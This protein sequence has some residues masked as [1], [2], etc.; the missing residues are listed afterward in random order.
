MNA[1]VVHEN[2]PRR[3]G[4]AGD[5]KGFVVSDLISR[6][7][8]ACSAGL[9][10]GVPEFL[11]DRRAKPVGGMTF[12]PLGKKLDLYEQFRSF[13]SDRAD[14]IILPCF[15]AH[16]FLEEVQGEVRLPVFPLFEALLAK[17]DRDYASVRRIGVLSTDFVQDSGL[18]ERHLAMSNRTVV[19]P[20]ADIRK[21]CVMPAMAAGATGF[22]EGLR[23]ACRHLIAAGAE[24][25]VPGNAELFQATTS[26]QVEGL[27]VLDVVQFY[28]D[29]IVSTSPAPLKKHFKIGVV[30]GVGPAATV[31]LL[32][33]IVVN[34]DARCDQEHV[35]IVVE[36]NPQIPDR[37]ANLLNGGLDPSVALYATCRRLQ[38]DD[39]NIIVIP[40][41]T[42]HAFVPRIQPYL[43]IP[44]VNMLHATMAYLGDRFP[45]QK[46]VGLLATSGTIE[47]RVYHDAAQSV[48]V[49]LLVPD[50]ENQAQVM[51]AIYGPRGVKAGYTEGECVERLLAAMTSLVLRGAEILILGCTELPLLMQANP[52][53]P[54]AGTTVAIVDP[55]EI[56][57][58]TCIR[59]AREHAAA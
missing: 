4:V 45:R 39:A 47:T 29:S 15:A 50:E 40:C 33:K 6:I 5:S 54:M 44:I 46:R 17:L 56:L 12:D 19:Y 51:A 26:L 1:S 24:V 25:I 49:E 14:A 8:A 36:Q 53:Y 58:R 41:N 57:A 11:A 13:E 37:T 55:T 18:F 28:A 9:N 20:D 30:G 32:N 22:L 23:Q 35:K 42:A 59:L 52:A 10:G 16:A 31:D 34:T 2:A 27:P 48:G 7:E 21:A 38:D 3:Y 43:S